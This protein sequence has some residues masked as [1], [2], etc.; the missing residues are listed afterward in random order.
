LVP[1]NIGA[2]DQ[3][4]GGLGAPLIGAQR[5]ALPLARLAVLTAKPGA[6]DGDPGLAE[7]SGQSPFAVAMPAAD[8]LRR[9]III[10]GLAPPIARPRQDRVQLFLQHRLD[11]PA[12][13]NAN[14]VLDR[15]EPILE[16]QNVGGDTRPLHG[17]LRHGVVSY[18]ALQ[19]WNRLG[20]ATRRLRQPISTTP[21]TGPEAGSPPGCAPITR[22]AQ[23][24]CT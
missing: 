19:R 14:R 12:H 1:E 17:I 5:L 15:I 22:A 7:G 11:K 23:V 13:P 24:K 8:D 20:S 9:C 6:R 21:A 3:R 18:P 2:G 4:I 16:K 10:A